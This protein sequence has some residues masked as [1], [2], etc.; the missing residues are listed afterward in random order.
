MLLKK[1]VDVASSEITPK[2]LFNRRKFLAGAAM[3]GAAALSGMRLLET[4]SP[5]NVAEANTKIDGVQKS[6]FS[7]TEKITPLKDVS[8]YNNYYEFSTDKY[9][10]AGL[11]KDFKTHPWTVKIDGLV[12]KKQELDIDTVMKMA[13]LKSALSPSVR[14]R[15]VHRSALGWFFP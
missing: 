9:E 11:A 1:S 10:P 6:S 7:T 4:S 15:M 14:R 3:A 5:E 8:N 2:S 12:A 13:L